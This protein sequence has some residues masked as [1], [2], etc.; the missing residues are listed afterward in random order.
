MSRTKRCIEYEK[1]S[2]LKLRNRPSP[3]PAIPVGERAEIGIKMG[4]DADKMFRQRNAEASERRLKFVEH[5][6]PAAESTHLRDRNI[7][8]LAGRRPNR[9]VPSAVGCIAMAEMAAEQRLGL[10]PVG[11]VGAGEDKTEWTAPT[12]AGLPI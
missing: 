9:S 7:H 5:C 4:R 3:L 2:W 12:F 11:D 10:V 6:R 1:I 8:K